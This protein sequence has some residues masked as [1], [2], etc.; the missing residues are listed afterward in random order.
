MK[1]LSPHLRVGF[2]RR[3][4]AAVL[5]MLPKCNQAKTIYPIP[6]LD[7]GHSVSYKA[8]MSPVPELQ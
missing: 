5:R 3:G 1:T 4:S 2:H 8:S 7:S 6:T